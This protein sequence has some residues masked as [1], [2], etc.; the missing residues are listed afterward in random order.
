M[1]EKITENVLIKCHHKPICI[2]LTGSYRF[3][4]QEATAI[5]LPQATQKVGK[6]KVA[7]GG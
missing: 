7:K 1:F 4:T 6:A 5:V 3:V 2:E